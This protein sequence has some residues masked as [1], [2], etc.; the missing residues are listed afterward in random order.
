MLSTVIPHSTP[1]RILTT[2]TN[3]MPGKLLFVNQCVLQETSTLLHVELTAGVYQGRRKEGKGRRTTSDMSKATRT[4]LRSR[5]LKDEIPLQSGIPLT[6]QFLSG[7][8]NHKVL[9]NVFLII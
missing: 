8:D 6:L 7:P 9:E 3:D 2:I 5:L 1:G 4:E